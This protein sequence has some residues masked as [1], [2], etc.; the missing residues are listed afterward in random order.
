MVVRWSRS[1][2]ASEG[3]SFQNRVFESGERRLRLDWVCGCVWGGFEVNFRRWV[4]DFGVFSAMWPIYSASE[5]ASASFKGVRPNP[6]RTRV[7][8][9]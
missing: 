1:I 7:S 8:L 5:R 3:K 6:R 9:D 4:E 2:A